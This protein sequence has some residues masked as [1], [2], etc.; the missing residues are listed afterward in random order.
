LENCSYWTVEYG[1]NPAELS[2]F[3]KTDDA[4]PGI[5][6]Q[7]SSSG[8]IPHF[9]QCDHEHTWGV[10]GEDRDGFVYFS[11]LDCDRACGI[12]PNHTQTSF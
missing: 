12:T 9:Y 11:Q 4:E 5:S 10:K 8:T 6:A 2:C 1:A 7:D 3:L